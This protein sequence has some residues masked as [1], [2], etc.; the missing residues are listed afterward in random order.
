MVA[1]WPPCFILPSSQYY[2]QRLSTP[3]PISF[4]WNGQ[5]FSVGGNEEAEK[6]DPHMMTDGSV[7]HNQL[8]QLLAEKSIS[9]RLGLIFF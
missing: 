4:I 8:K 7:G 1:G 3:K 6:T 2:L 5:L 9:R